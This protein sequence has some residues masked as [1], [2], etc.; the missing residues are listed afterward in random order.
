MKR[1][2][3]YVLSLIVLMFSMVYLG[4]DRVTVRASDGIDPSKVFGIQMLW[5]D[6]MDVYDVAVSKDSNYIAVVNNTG[7]YYFESNNSSMRWWYP[8]GIT[9]ISV[10]VSAD[11]EYVAVGD[12]G[13]R[14]YYFNSSR[15]AVGERVNATW[16]SRYLY[17]PVERGTLDISDD[18][19]YVVVGGT[20][21]ILYYFA[22]CRARAGTDE[23]ETWLNNIYPSV[24]DYRTVH[25]SPNGQYVAAGGYNTY[26]TGFVTFYKNANNYTSPP[27]EPDWYAFSSINGSVLIRDLAVSDDGYAVAAVDG[28]HTLHYWA[29]ATNLSG[30]PNATWTNPA[31]SSVDFSHVDMSADGNSVVAGSYTLTSLHFWANARNRQGTQTEDWVR[32]ESIY[33]GDVAIS[34]NGGIIAVS[35]YNSSSATPNQ[36]CFFKSNGDLIRMFPLNNS[37]LVSIAGNGRIASAAGPTFDSLYVFEVLQDS[38][39]PLIENVYQVPVNSS[40]YPSDSVMVFANITDDNGVK[41]ATLNYTYTNSSGTFSGLVTMQNLEGTAY[42]GTIPQFSYLTDVTYVIVAEDNFSNINTTEEMG[43]T[44]T[45]QVIPEFPS[46][47]ILAALATATLTAIAL[48]KK[49]R[50]HNGKLKK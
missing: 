42:N 33:V 39:P 47:I 8:S 26:A 15:S 31:D 29:N 27:T 28:N 45:Y 37:G 20:G 30:D 50:L 43:Q 21:Q 41:Q 44:Y 48:R 5:S 6:S 2:F 22:G 7:L 11:G 9:L 18:G 19:E 12:I 32:L 23:T 1:D 25:I 10:V 3:A 49:N 4:F 34:D 38:T 17:G 36:A 35:A 13:G 14:I 16:R 24:N 40:V 46:Q